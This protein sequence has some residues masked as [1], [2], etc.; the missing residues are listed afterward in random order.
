[1]RGVVEVGAGLSGMRQTGRIASDN[2]E[3]DASN[4]TTAGVPLHLTR[5]GVDHRR[6]ENGQEGVGG[7]EDP[8]LE[9]RQVLLDTHGQGDV[10]GFGPASQGVQEEQGVVKAALLLQ[11]T[12]RLTHQQGVAVVHGIAQLEGKYAVRLGKE[13]NQTPLSLL[14]DYKRGS[15]CVCVCVGVY[16]SPTL[17][18]A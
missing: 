1:M 3:L 13:Q 11:A 10:V 15:V 2:V 18:T 6:G 5:T 8:V 7:I 4:K 12:L 14:C 9:T 16:D 17:P